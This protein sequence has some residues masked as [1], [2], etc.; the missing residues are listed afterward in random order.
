MLQIVQNLMFYKENS[1]I[2][3]KF[4]K[5]NNKIMFSGVLVFDVNEKLLKMHVYTQLYKILQFN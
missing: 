1:L 2:I 5:Q 4:N 3:F